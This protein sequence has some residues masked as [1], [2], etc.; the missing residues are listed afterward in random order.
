MSE[1]LEQWRTGLKEFDYSNQVMLLALFGTIG[2][3]SSMLDVGCGTGAMVRTARALGVDACG[4]DQLVTPEYGQGFFKHDLSQPIDLERKFGMVT[5]I[6]VAEHLQ[7]EYA[8]TFCDTLA[9]H[10]TATGLLIF[11]AAMPGQAGFNHF[12]C[13]H[14]QYWADKLYARGMREQRELTYKLALAWRNAPTA[15][16]YLAANLS[17]WW[18]P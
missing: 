2:I 9:K 5:T 3:P 12:N 10:V 7:P 11:T 6:E 16:T 4:I 1:E 14:V 17:V 8:D 18:K 13:Q 15:I